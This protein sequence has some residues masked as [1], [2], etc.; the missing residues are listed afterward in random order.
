MHVFR[1]NQG[2]LHHQH[3][4]AGLQQSRSQISGVLRGDT[5]GKA[6]AGIPHQAQASL[7]EIH[8]QRLRVQALENLVGRSVIG[9][10]EG[11]VVRGGV[12]RRIKAFQLS[13]GRIHNL[14]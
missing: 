4:H 5:H 2:A 1:R 13:A 12:E 9:G 8:V 14:C 7:Q 3:V 10:L 11:G 6:H